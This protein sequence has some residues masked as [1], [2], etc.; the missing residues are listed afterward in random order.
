MQFDKIIFRGCSTRW[1]LSGYKEIFEIYADCTTEMQDLTEREAFIKE[2]AIGMRIIIEAM[3][4]K[5]SDE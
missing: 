3:A 4:T 2:F 5:I 1:G